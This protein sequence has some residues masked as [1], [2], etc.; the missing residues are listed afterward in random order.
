MIELFSELD[1]DGNNVVTQE[2]FEYGL[3]EM[4]VEIDNDELL[5]FYQMLEAD[6]EGKSMRFP[7]FL[8]LLQSSIHYLFV[9]PLTRL[10]SSLPFH[11]S[12]RWLTSSISLSQR[13]LNP[14]HQATSRTISS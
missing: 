6:E 8:R 9:Q 2:E 7:S 3:L 14:P 1:Q 11:L 13:T 12:I 10:F 4:G 5:E